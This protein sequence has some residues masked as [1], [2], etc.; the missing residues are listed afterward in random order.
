MHARAKG[1]AG[2][3]AAA[4]GSVAVVGILLASCGGNDGGKPAA[5]VT[6]SPLEPLTAVVTQSGGAVLSPV[7]SDTPTAAVSPSPSAS[8]APSKT[9]S[10]DPKSAAYDAALQL[11]NAVPAEDCSDNNPDKKACLNWSTTP[12]TPAR[13]VAAFNV[14]SAQ[15]GGAMMVTGLEA[16]GVTWGV[17]FGTQQA[18]Y[19]AVS[20]PADML[21][22]A[23]GNGLT[24]HESHSSSSDTVDTVG[25]G[26]VVR[27][28]EFVL[29]APGSSGSTGSGW[30]RI[31]SP[32]EGW[33]DATDL[34]VASLGDC[35]FHDALQGNGFDRG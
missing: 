29:T 5:N 32:V 34:S 3:I 28:E 2:R 16:D 1:R 25:D 15:G 20:L 30:Y 35:S 33:A 18:L 13:G 4:V 12:S 23:G 17:W 19:Q 27:A 26:K 9:T 31:S 8:A 11:F 14:G 7:P 10:D 22:C 24:V 6:F 21:V